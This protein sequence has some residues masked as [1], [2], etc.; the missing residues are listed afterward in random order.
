MRV[1]IEKGI[2]SGK[3]V[4]P[5]SKSMAHRM[6][7]CAALARGT[8]TICGVSSCDDVLATIECLT[9]LGARFEY[10]GDTVKV[11]G[12]DLKAASPEG[13]LHC[14]ESGSTLRFLIPVCWL[15]DKNVML[16]GEGALMKRPLGV[17]EALAKEKGVSFHIAM[18]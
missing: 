10:E 6:L 12:T 17:Y 2:A 14:R 3:V 8:S 13:R 11:T 18:A 15:L 4:A 5:P 1:E 9:R 7:I 16:T